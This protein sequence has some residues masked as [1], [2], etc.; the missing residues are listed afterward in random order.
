[1]SNNTRQGEG[2]SIRI[3]DVLSHLWSKKY[4]FI[5]IIAAFTAAAYL[6][7]YFFTAPK[8]VSTAKIVIIQASDTGKISSADVTVSTYLVND[9]IELVADRTVLEKVNEELKLNLSY[10]QLRRMVSVK[11]PENSR[12]L[13]VSVVTS[14]PVRSQT[15]AEKIC[16]VAKEKIASILDVDKVNIFSH[17]S[18]PANDSSTPAATTAVLGAF[19]GI[20]TVIII[21]VLFAYFDDKLRSPE[22]VEKYTGLPTLASIPYNERK[23][24]KHSRSVGRKAAEK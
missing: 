22:E 17:A 23:S 18:L 11:N 12:I 3:S 8:Y 2:D 15:I 13:E 14:D 9:Y 21:A 10:E 16:V 19:A 24:G 20:A 1:M 7:A 4:L 6:Y 5:A